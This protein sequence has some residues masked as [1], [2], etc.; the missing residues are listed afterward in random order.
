MD[1]SRSA[2]RSG[3]PR[4]PEATCARGVSFSQGLADKKV[5]SVWAQQE[6]GRSSEA[7]RHRIS[8]RDSLA[9]LCGLSKLST[10]GDLQDGGQVLT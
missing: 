5:G 8:P 4:L 9:G 6:V 7:E 10:P 2:W 3:A 1:H